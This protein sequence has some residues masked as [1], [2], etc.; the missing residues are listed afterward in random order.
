[1]RA[2][3]AAPVLGL[4]L[5]LLALGPGLRRGFLLSYDMV[6]VP[7]EPLSAALPGL[8]PPRAVP[9]DVVVAI[10]SRLIPADVTEKLLLL[11][12]FTLA[13]AGMAALLDQEPLLARL[14]AG[15]FYAWNPYV[16]ERLIIGQWALLLGY[17]GL[18]WVLRAVLVGRPVRLCLAL[19]PAV[20]GGFTALTVT[21]LLAVPV[22]LLTRSARTAWLTAGVLA[23]GSLPWLIPSLLHPV[24][25]DPAGIA[26]FAARADTPFGTIGSLVML[27]GM[28]N[29]QTVPAAYGGPWSALWLV[30]AL[31]AVAGFA[32][33]ACSGA[34][35]R[36]SVKDRGSLCAS[37]Y[38]QRSTITPTRRRLAGR[39]GSGHLSSTPMTSPIGVVGVDDRLLLGRWRRRQA[40]RWPGLGVAAAAGLVIA[41]AGVTAGGREFLRGA[42]E[43]WPGFA[44][45]R[46][47]QQFV[48][49]LA[50][51]EAAGF[52]LLVASA[53]QPRK[54]R[55]ADQRQ[56]VADRQQRQVAHPSQQATDPQGW[57]IALTALVAPVLLL[58][59]LAW[60]AAGRLRPVW[61]PPA[62]LAAARVIDAA[63]GPGAV[64]LL[65]WAADRRP[66]WNGGEALLDPWPRLLSRPVIWNDGTQVG[67]VRLAP[68]DPQ[69]RELN[70]IAASQAP[71]TAALRAAGVRFVLVDAGPRPSARLPGFTMIIDQ[72]G[73]AVYELADGP[74]TRSRMS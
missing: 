15:V 17:A 37:P 8:A 48:A 26:A 10:A 61:Y 39:G 29:A 69:A 11:S 47:G 71:L 43:A 12:I 50:L 45:L 73:L 22:A 21:A 13:C 54:A 6:L 16:G 30:I 72:P 36:G 20:V 7:R 34:D 55:A 51:A 32:R 24:Y 52:G 67:D 65:P 62:W 2:R 35:A 56:R 25:A 14:A 68:D 70:T 23:V 44:V 31:A 58:P 53:L 38:T 27:G 33:L 19:L 42:M 63:P 18:P 3:A 57:A 60:G 59:G 41:S 64:L 9:S 66:A 28:W 4:C 46:D 49:P 5:G 1:V 74:A 40:R